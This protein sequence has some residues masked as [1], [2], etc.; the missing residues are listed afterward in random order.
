MSR[1]R[2]IL[3]WTLVV[4]AS[5]IALVSAMTVWTKRQLL[6]TDAWVNSSSEVLAEPKVQTALSA[7]LTDLLYQRVDVQGQLQQQLPPQAKALAPVAAAAVKSA[8]GRVIEAFLA[9]PAAQDLWERLNRRAHTALVNVLEGNEGGR[10]STKNGDVV[11]DLRPLLQR[12]EGR[13]GIVDR[14]RPEADETTG[15]IVIL[16]S[17]QLDAAQKAV[18]AIKVLSVWLVLL[19][20][21]LYALAIYLARGHR[22]TVLQGCGVGF[23]LVGLILLIV[24]RVLGN[25]IIDSLVPNE[26]GKEAG[27]IVWLIETNLLRDIGI[28]MIAYGIVAIVA[29]YLAGPG[30]WATAIRQRLA[31]SF[32]ER[33]AAVYA[34]AVALLLLI[35]AWGPTAASRRLLGIVLLGGLLLIGLEVWRRQTI[36]EFPNGGTAP[37]PAAPA[38]GAPPPEITRDG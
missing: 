27:N 38:G 28:A 16:R 6:D 12:I 22:R 5:V 31:P 8:S 10:I 35:V 9:S 32:R 14:V 2:S 36:R 15:E 24:R 23:V 18:Q 25:V 26:S 13:L 17:N 4:I 33:P 7:R 19:V 30:R 1:R 11:L 37:V 20:L 34:V 3:V 29:G 21:G